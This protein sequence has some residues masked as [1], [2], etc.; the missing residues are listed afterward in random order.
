MP[1]QMTSQEYWKE[2]H[3]IVDSMIEEREPDDTEEDL[4][5]R[6]WET[7]DGHQWVIYT[8]YNYEVLQH[9]DNDG[10]YVDNFGEDGTVENGMLRTDRLAFGAL[11]AD[12][13]D[14]FSRQEV[15]Y[16]A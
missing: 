10:Y 15:E 4:Q 5:E 13:M 1:D 7:V 12:C 2:V 3:S 8:G 9:S 16:A 11:Y 14:Y 6:L